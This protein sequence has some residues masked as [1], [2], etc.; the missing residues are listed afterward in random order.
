[1]AAR[2]TRRTASCTAGDGGRSSGGLEELGGH[3]LTT[4]GAGLTHL[5]AASRKVSLMKEVATKLQK[6][7]TV[8]TLPRDPAMM[9]LISSEARRRH[10]A[11]PTY[12][13]RM[14]EMGDIN[15]REV[16]I[17]AIQD[18]VAAAKKCVKSGMMLRATMHDVR[19]A[20]L[21]AV[22]QERMPPIRAKT[23]AVDRIQNV[24]MQVKKQ[25]TAED[26]WQRLANEGLASTPMM[27]SASKKL[28]KL[29]PLPPPSPSSTASPQAAS[30][31][32]SQ[33]HRGSWVWARRASSVA[34]ALMP[35][36]MTSPRP[37]A[38]GGHDPSSSEPR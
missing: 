30:A 1:M 27:C 22:V 32:A 5:V 2:R 29:D 17:E 15:P 38:D 28:G 35:T 12:Q 23:L 36:A 3:G 10:L 24:Y 21:R 34:R 9:R 11:R 25:E 18:V 33:H 7:V 6:N 26:M 20:K 16:L 37:H 19:V 31:S 8:G 4:G 13:A 14:N